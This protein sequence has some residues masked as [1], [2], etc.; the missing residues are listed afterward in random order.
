MKLKIIF[1]LTIITQFFFAQTNTEI[2]KLK[3][4]AAI[5]GVV[6]YFHP[7]DENA[8]INWNQFAAYGTEQILKTKNQQEFERVLKKLFVPIA[9]TISFEG[10][11]Y[12]WNQNNLVPIFWIHKGLGIDAKKKRNAFKSRRFNRGD[13]EKKQFNYVFINLNPEGMYSNVKITYEAKSGNG[14]ESYV[15]ANLY[16]KGIEKE[17]FKTHQRNPVTSEEW[18]KKELLIENDLPIEKIN[19]GLLCTQ[20]DS[21]FR[22]VKLWYQNK[23]KEW[24]LYEL[25]KLTNQD[26]KTN[27]PRLLLKRTE[28]EIKFLD[29]SENGINP[30]NVTWDKFVKLNL[31]N[32]LTVVIPTLVYSDKDN[33]LPKTGKK[34]L[35]EIQ[36]LLKN[37]P[38]NRDIAIANVMISWNIF[39]H[40]SPYQDVIKTNW[41]AVL[42]KSLKDAFDD[43]NEYDN[44][45]TL[46]RSTSNFDD[47]HMAV[48]YRGLSETRK[49][50]PKIA[51]RYINNQLMV[52]NIIGK[53]EGINNGDIITKIDDIE[54]KKYIDS[55]QQYISGSKQYKNWISAQL[56]I[57]GSKDSFINFQLKNG[58]NITLKRDTEYI[59]NSDFYTR[60]DVTKSKEINAET[61]YVNMDK[62]SA[63]EME[64]EIPNIRKHKNLI[65]D[66]RGYPRTDQNHVLLNYLLPKE[67]TTKWLCGREIYLPDFKYFTEE[68]NGHRNRSF[69]SDNPLKTNNVLLVDE[70]SVSNAEMFSQV[71]KHYK[72]ATIIG[73]T[74]AGANGNRN[75]ID[76]LNDFQISFTGLKVINPDGSRFHAIGVLPDIIVNETSEDLKIGKDVYLEKAMEV[77]EG[78][79]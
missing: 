9:P 73:R 51:V 38:F 52:K 71:I 44:Y 78:G 31:S 5:Y 41:N 72:L 64:E 67:D 24:L 11:E 54:T 16:N 2:Q 6:R 35:I 1:F 13:A 39:K 60:D 36:S 63:K 26:W 74:T 62:L 79:K 33:T 43:K 7:S 56:S 49:F 10:K 3:D 53:I 50:A 30:Y 25:P 66:L 22:D 65:I 12:Q 21:E 46:S 58:K 45:L 75:D 59:V 27:N 61:Y 28:N 55:L 14:G 18:E 15:Y 69:I 20:S 48:Y 17:N 34:D 42:E 77:F 76:L 8:K 70:R 32:N 19:F 4:F 47:G 29:D 37:I 40:F 57:R 68:C 23:N